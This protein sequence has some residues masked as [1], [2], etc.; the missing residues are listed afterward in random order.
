MPL[1]LYTYIATE[2][3][4][5][6]F[7]SFL[8][9][10][11]ILF[12]GKLVPLLNMIFD[13]GVGSGD[14]LRL[15]AYMLPNLMLFSI[16]MASMTAV[17]VAVTRM[18]N[19]NEIMAL[20]ANGIGLVRLLPPVFVIALATSLL[21][22]FSAVTLIPQ[23]TLAMKTLFIQMAKEKIDQGVQPG[24]FSEGLANVVLY[25]DAVD[26]QTR[27]WQGVYVS[28]MRHGDTPM[29]IVAKTG[30]LTAQPEKMLL[31]LSL[32]DGTLHRANENITQTIRFD[33]YQVNLPIKAP[34][35]IAGTSL[36]EV[37]K[38]GLSQAQLLEQVTRHG[39]KSVIGMG[40]LMEY[41]VRMAMPAGGFILTILGL[42]LAM[43]A[44]PGRRPVG[45][46]LGLL[47]FVLYYVLFTAGRAI[48]ESGHLPVALGLW[49]SNILMAFF[50]VMLTRQVAKESVPLFLT[51]LSGP[52]LA[53][54]ARLP[55]SKIGGK[56]P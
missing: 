43:L 23:G 33:R 21:T 55:G 34:T 31:T 30:T 44:R 52:A 51:R 6:F 13:F 37:G 45:V 11:A 53:L 41:H 2:I 38:N 9:I 4:A 22:Y 18:V 56:L 7:A 48:A 26:P 46:P 10:N 32:A 20:K 5:P 24:Q 49:L 17:I 3:L 12:L 35:E 54:L 19:D 1:L 39:A 42:P 27:Q 16:P 25:I 28:D 15:C 29:T 40:M 50:T 47:F 36:S 14:F 8:I